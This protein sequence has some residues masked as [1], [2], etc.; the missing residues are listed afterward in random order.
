MSTKGLLYYLGTEVPG[1][2]P[3]PTWQCKACGAR[4]RSDECHSAREPYPHRT[5][6]TLI[7]DYWPIKEA[8]V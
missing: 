3:G 2:P 7:V 6:E 8:K 1:M 4:V 5:L